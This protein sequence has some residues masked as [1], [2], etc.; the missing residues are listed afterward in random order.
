MFIDRR[1]LEAY[2]LRQE[3]HVS[4]FEI[5]S[6]HCHATHIALLTDCGAFFLR[7]L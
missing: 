1:R 7:G 2:A 4:R 5:A 6:L 3:C